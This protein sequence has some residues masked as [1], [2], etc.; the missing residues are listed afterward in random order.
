M[1]DEIF[2]QR[3]FRSSGERAITTGVVRKDS[4]LSLSAIL[5]SSPPLPHIWGKYLSRAWSDMWAVIF[6]DEYLTKQWRYPIELHGIGKYGND[7]YRIFC[8]NEWKQVRS[9][10]S[11]N[12][13]CFW[14]KISPLLWLKQ[15]L[16]QACY[17]SS[18]LG[19]WMACSYWQQG[20][21]P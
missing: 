9:T 16:R 6:S 3:C 4:F 15:F 12:I 21:D 19:Q 17:Y 18:K 14:D 5:P 8:I 10:G 2:R 1:A 13:S 7:S 20:E 11:Q